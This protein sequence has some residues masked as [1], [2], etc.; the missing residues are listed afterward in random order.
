MFGV[1]DAGTEAAVSAYVKLLRA[2]R[3]VMAR[4]EPRLVALGL[5]PTQLGVL[6]GLLHK[7]A[8]THRDLG[9]KVLTSAANMTDVIDKLEARGLVVRVRCPE[10]RRQVRVELTACGR[11]LIEDLFPRHAADIAAAMGGLDQAALEE[12]GNLLRKLGM[13]A[14][15]S[16]DEAALVKTCAPDHLP[17]RPFDI[18]QLGACNDPGSTV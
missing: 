17:P 15:R 11:E 5:T 7:G 12:L 10:D 14:A 6:E 4:V 9:R 18:E 1:T 16:G 13:A 8:L 3:A 2:T